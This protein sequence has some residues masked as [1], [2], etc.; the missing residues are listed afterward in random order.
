MVSKAL[1]WFFAGA[2]AFHAFTHVFYW[3]AGAIPID[4]KLFMVTPVLNQIELWGS[5][6]LA[7]LFIHLGKK[8]GV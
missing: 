1:L 3:G 4:F 5:V 2:A 6:I 8:Y 7:V